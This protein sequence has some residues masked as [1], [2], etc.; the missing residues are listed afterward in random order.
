MNS[1]AQMRA[2]KGPAVLTFGFRP[3]FLGASVWALSAML[4]W[5]FQLSGMPDLPTN[6]DPVTWHAHEFLFGYL[7]AVVAGFLLTAV[8]NW[9][10]RLPVV[11]WSLGVL[12]GLWVMGRTAI[13]LGMYLPSWLVALA[14][15]SMPLA[16]VGFLAREIL[17]GKNWRNLIVLALLVA[18]TLA[19]ARFHWEAYDDDMAGRQ[20][21]LRAGLGTG[22]M[23]IALIGGRIVPSFT[24]N[25][26]V[27]QGETRLPA[28]PMQRY[29]V[30]ALLIL[31]VAIVFWILWPESV[32]SGGALVLA[33]GLHAL[34]L[35][36]WAGWYS[37]SEPLVWILHVA[38]AFLPL[39]AF[40]LGFSILWPALLTQTAAQHV[41]M[42]G[43][44]GVM[45]VAVMTRA[46]LGHT[47]QKLTAGIGTFAIYLALISAV[48]VRLVAGFVPS[49]AGLLFTFSGLFWI[50]AFGG[51]VVVY[52][53]LLLRVRK[54]V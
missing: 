14:D 5:I 8:P 48:V 34:R 21:G 9:T 17:A 16:L 7:G 3:F 52:G 33:A 18:F 31:F 40:A 26:L 22:I 49:M 11:G 46:T 25:W 15:L 36:R 50:L 1:A 51:F 54:A 20:M 28:P 47:G 44:I 19:N 29:D 35:G 38:Y 39:G 37:I 24:R 27:K 41:W 13:L 4:L 42:A 12:F 45:T 30:V 2:W 43:A 10:G 6:F 53:P 32:G 23:M